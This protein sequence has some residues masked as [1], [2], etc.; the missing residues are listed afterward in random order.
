MEDTHDVSSEMDI[1]HD[2]KLDSIQNSGATTSTPCKKLNSNSHV[3]MGFFGGI[4]IALNGS[5][6][7]FN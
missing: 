2:V 1:T 5:L 4:I 7:L 6:A 3:H